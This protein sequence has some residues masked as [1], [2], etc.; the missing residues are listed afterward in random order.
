M[1]NKE[2]EIKKA[3]KRSKIVNTIYYI[4][5]V[6]WTIG[7]LRWVWLTV[8]TYYNYFAAVGLLIVVDFILITFFLWVSGKVGRIKR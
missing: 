8:N 2:E 6:L 3:H 5:M 7:W 1:Y 4:V